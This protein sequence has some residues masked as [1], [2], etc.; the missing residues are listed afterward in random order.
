MGRGG[1]THQ[2]G[3]LGTEP[4]ARGGTREPGREPGTQLNWCLAGTPGLGTIDF[5]HKN[6]NLIIFKKKKQ[7]KHQYFA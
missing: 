3:E 1:G 6:S 4:R 7:E 2:A 5:F